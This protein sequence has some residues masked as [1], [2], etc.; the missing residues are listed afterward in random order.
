MGRGILD[1]R[2]EDI[3]GTSIST[4]GFHSFQTSPHLTLVRSSFPMEKRVSTTRDP[5]TKLK[6]STQGAKDLT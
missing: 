2:S 6:D 4:F 3:C 5:G 1:S